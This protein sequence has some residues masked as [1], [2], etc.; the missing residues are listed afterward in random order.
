MRCVSAPF[1]ILLKK[2]DE[3]RAE[4]KTALWW[5][6]MKAPWHERQQSEVSGTQF[7]ACTPPACPSLD[8]H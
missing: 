4:V 8:Q 7:R 1:K 6:L 2:R 5:R 3:K